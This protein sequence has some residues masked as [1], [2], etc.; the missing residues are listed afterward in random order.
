MPVA[1]ATECALVELLLDGLSKLVN[2]MAAT[3]VSRYLCV[4]G[5]LLDRSADDR[6]KPSG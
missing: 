1:T 3:A 5:G 2:Y 4:D 6:L